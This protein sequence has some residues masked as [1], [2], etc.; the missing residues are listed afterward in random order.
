MEQENERAERGQKVPGT[1]HQ[2]RHRR[3]GMGGVGSVGLRCVHEVVRRRPDADVRSC[4]TFRIRRLLGGE[5]A[6]QRVEG[7]VHQHLLGAETQNCRLE[8]APGPSRQHHA[9]DRQHCQSS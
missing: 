6:R 7:Q 2:R 3:H 5:V 9:R 1:H 8:P 4:S